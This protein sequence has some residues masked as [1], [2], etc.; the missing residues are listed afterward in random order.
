VGRRLRPRDHGEGF[1]ILRHANEGVMRLLVALHPGA[2]GAGER[3]P[4]VA[5]ALL[6]ICGF[7]RR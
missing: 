1:Q 7:N 6:G 4:S 2:R 3:G 5:M